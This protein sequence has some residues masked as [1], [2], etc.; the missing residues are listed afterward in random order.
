MQECRDESEICNGI[1]GSI[2]NQYISKSY[3]TTKNTIDPIGDILIHQMKQTV[4]L[5]GHFE[6]VW[7][8]GLRWMSSALWDCFGVISNKSPMQP[9]SGQYISVLDLNFL[10]RWSLD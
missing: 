2:I 3:T 6:V 5:I 4:N 9:Q 7:E 10:N 8:T 1:V